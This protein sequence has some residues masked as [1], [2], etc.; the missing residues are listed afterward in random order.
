MN[1]RYVE[2][3]EAFRNIC[4]YPAEELK[5]LDYWT[6]TPKKYAADEARQLESLERVGRY[7]PYEKEYIRK[8]GSVIPLR[9]NGMLITGNDGRNY[10]WSIVEDIADRKLAERQILELNV[11]LERRV[12]ERTRQLEAFSYSVSHDLRAPLRA[13]QGFSQILAEQYAGRL[14]AAGREYLDRILRAAARMGELI[15]DLLQLAHVSGSRLTVETVNL[16]EMARLVLGELQEREPGRNVAADV[17]DGV[18]ARGD[19]KLLRIV[20]DNL[21]GNAWKFTAKKEQATIQFGATTQDGEQVIFVKDNGAGFD[22]SYAD[23]LFGVFQ[24]LHG[25]NEFEGTGVGLATVER[26]VALHGGRIWAAADVGK[27]ATF[28]F[29]LAPKHA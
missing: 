26:V 10:I 6:L 8:D 9:L 3:N 28:Y 5:V 13:I 16:S 21:L 23:R 20:L 24:R 22:M 27:G 12:A 29:T 15:D 14:E 25:A 11:D 17:Q 1:G 19:A 7:G 4:G 18:S 2:F